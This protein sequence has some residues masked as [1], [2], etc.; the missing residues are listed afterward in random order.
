M[1]WVGNDLCVIIPNLC[2][3][4]S[5]LAGRCWRQ[6]WCF[7]T[8][9]GAKPYSSVLLLTIQ[10][11]AVRATATTSGLSGRASCD[12][13]FLLQICLCSGAVPASL[14]PSP[15]H[16]EWPAEGTHGLQ[17]HL[18]QRAPPF[19]YV[20]N[21]CVTHRA[22]SSTGEGC[23]GFLIQRQQNGACQWK[24]SLVLPVAACLLLYWCE[25]LTS[26]MQKT[27]PSFPPLSKVSLFSSHPCMA[28][29]IHIVEFLAADL[30]LL[31]LMFLVF[32]GE[33]TSHLFITL[34]SG[35]H[36][37]S[38]PEQLSA[39]TTF[40]DSMGL[41]FLCIGSK[42]ILNNSQLSF[43]DSCSNSFSPLFCL[44]IIFSFVKLAF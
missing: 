13:P 23:W 16:G 27:K 39:S 25:S 28:S 29:L 9:E 12:G 17:P 7:L 44:V 20:D 41:W 3:C 8:L 40:F 34:W 4:R 18:G 36:L 38:Q 6:Q 2:R 30:H 37:P 35:S 14:L 5:R 22:D 43:T 15:C 26:C 10:R 42:M 31:P 32:H 33:R 19:V 11:H 21:V 1:G 24:V